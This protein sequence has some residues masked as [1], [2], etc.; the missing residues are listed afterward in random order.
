[1]VLSYLALGW[2]LIKYLIESWELNK[3]RTLWFAGIGALVIMISAP[4]FIFTFP[5]RMFL[6]YIMGNRYDS[7]TFILFK[8]FA[9]VVFMSLVKNTINKW[10]WKESLIMALAI[11]GATLAKPSLT[12]TLI[13]AIGILLLFK[14]K[15]WK[16]TNWFYLVGPFGLVAFLVLIVQ[17]IIGFVGDRGD[18]IIFDPFTEILIHVPNLW[19]VLLF[20]IMSIV[21]PIFISIVYWKK[22]KNDFGFQLAWINFFVALAYGLLLAEQINMGVN[23]FWNSCM[24][25]VF[26][27]FFVTVSFWGRK[28]FINLRSPDKFTLKDGL[29]S[30]WIPALLL[31]L[32]FVCGIIYYVAIL[33]SSSVNVN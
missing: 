4:I 20:I 29:V 32:H 14:I 18:R 25:A 15:E 10:D 23:N 28:I 31:G 3:K 9:L 17:F 30:K 21:F 22:I 8:P 19:M 5:K 16:K 24:I 13:P 7:P 26:V 1:M 33:F 12:I 27:L 6:G 11:W 2:I